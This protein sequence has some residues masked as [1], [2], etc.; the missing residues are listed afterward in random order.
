VTATWDFPENLMTA[1]LTRAD[2]QFGSPFLGSPLLVEPRPW[3][4]WTVVAGLLAGWAVGTA[5]ALRTREGRGLLLAVVGS[6]LLTVAA[7][8][9]GQWPV[10]FVR[11]NLFLVPL[12]YVVAGIGAFAVA[13]WTWAVAPRSWRGGWAFGVLAFLTLWLVLAGAVAGQR[14]QEMRTTAGAPMLLGRM[15]A[16]VAFQQGRARPGDVQVVIPGRYDMGQWYKAQ[17]YYA[18]YDDGLR[19]LGVDDSDTLL[20]PP[21]PRLWRAPLEDFLARHPQAGGLFLVTYNLVLPAE[22]KLMEGEL[23]RLGWCDTG[24]GASWRL[25][26]EITYLRRCDGR[27]AS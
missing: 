2:G 18:R 15:D 8:T 24:A 3:L 9:R 23:A 21:R 26:G 10:G 20:E 13:R 6:F 19:G 12:L 7:A 16:L 11:A 22:R 27:P 25:T 4:R 5:V 1:A 17:Q 14:I